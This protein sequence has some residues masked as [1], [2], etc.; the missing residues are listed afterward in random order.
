M[1]AGL[2]ERFA[3]EAEVSSVTDGWILG[4]FRFWL[5]GEPVGNWEDSAALNACANWLSDFAAK[6]CNRYEP[7][8]VGL[9]AQEAFQRG[10]DAAMQD[11]VPKIE[12]AYS[13]FF[14]SQLGMSSFDRYD[15]LLLKDAEGME[16]CLWRCREDAICE[17]CLN[18]NE[19]E[20]VAAQFCE[21][22]ERN[23]GHIPGTPPPKAADG[24]VFD[25]SSLRRQ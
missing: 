11:D 7:S 18:P 5:C 3:I 21:I 20:S 10:Y 9:S 8:L 13:R 25:R 22:F 24:G 16:R 19:M 12:N 4:R 17:C 23:T 6:P 1:I 14:I 2:K 15:I